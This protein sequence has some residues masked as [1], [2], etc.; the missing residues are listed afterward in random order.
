MRALTRQQRR[1]PRVIVSS[2]Y[3]PRASAH[4]SYR[5]NFIAYEPPRVLAWVL[6]ART[7]RVPP[8][9]AYRTTAIYSTRKHPLH[10]HLL[11][12][13]PGSPCPTRS[14]PSPDARVATS[15]LFLTLRP[16][17]MGERRPSRPYLTWLSA[18]PDQSGGIRSAVRRG[19][20]AAHAGARPWR[21][22]GRR[23]RRTPAARVPT[24]PLARAAA[25]RGVRAQGAP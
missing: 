11:R 1:A 24:T 20:L 12:R 10:S 2:N 18:G 9:R 22:R 7:S 5:L 4:D 8:S 3:A 13:L 15:I 25:T 14:P 19:P 17:I 6:A 16:S 23:S 21:A